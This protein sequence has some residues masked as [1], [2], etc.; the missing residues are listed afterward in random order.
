MTLTQIIITYTG[1]VQAGK[2]YKRKTGLIVEENGLTEL[3]KTLQVIY[4][5]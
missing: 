2:S 4:I 5:H 3:T 1:C